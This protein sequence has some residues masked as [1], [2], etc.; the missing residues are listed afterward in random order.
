MGGLRAGLAPPGAGPGA[1]GAGRSASLTE[2]GAAWHD[3]P[4]GWVGESGE[5]G[6]GSQRGGM[7]QPGPKAP[8][9]PAA[10]ARARTLLDVFFARVDATPD[11][12]AL[13][14]MEVDGRTVTTTWRQWEQRSRA[15]A[16]GL[17]DLGLAPGAR[18]ALLSQTRLEW[19]LLD[20]AILMAG[21]ISVP[22]YANEQPATCARLLEDSGARVAIAENPWQ[23]KKLLDMDPAISETLGLILIE[24]ELRLQTGASA[25]TAELGVRAKRVETLDQLE[26]RG[27]RRLAT[28]DAELD[29]RIES[30][31]PDACVTICY[32]PGTEGREKGVMLTHEGFVATCGAL[33]GVL[34]LGA[35]DLQLL[36]LPLAQAFGR[37]GLWFGVRAGVPTALA[38][39]WRTVFE[40]ARSWQ[41]TCLWGA[42]RL[43]EKAQEG[44]ESELLG[45]GGL[46]SL[47]AGWA[48]GRP[49]DRPVEGLLARGRHALGERLVKRKVHARFGGRLRFA[50]SGGA[51][52]GAETARFFA[53]RDLPILESYG[54]VETTAATHIARLGEHAPGTVGRALPG[55]EFKLLEDGE[56]L[57]RG[58]NVTPG[59]WGSPAETRKVFDPEGWFH[60]GDL[61]RLD[62]DGRLVITDRKRDI[63]VTANG[64]AIAP[65]P[66]AERLRADPV[67]GQ[68]YI[69]GDRR[70]FLTAL[71]HLDAEGLARLAADLDL[72]GDYEHLTRHPRVFAYVDAVVDRVNATLSPHETIRKF[73]LMASEPTTE[74]GVLTPMLGLRRRVYADKHKALLDSF[75]SEP[76]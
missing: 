53:T 17:L 28:G 64:K 74:S 51:P 55:V 76:F 60:T 12:V 27:R 41:P 57:V 39:S 52:L 72:E 35:D 44:I 11:V 71:I 58:P 7:H 61:A 30:I 24:S 23:L 70:T 1:A 50:V 75:Y 63:I 69:H 15:L 45:S 16:S 25:T 32:T 18:V 34:P 6:E 31:E 26:A 22:I 46:M 13:R 59:Y 9:A 14:T 5:M 42:P 3:R 2:V 21:G 20:A 36:Y 68:V 48:L 4:A 67:I 47:V 37:L 8:P 33:A 38:R 40:D 54:M 43:F 49:P 73:A 56:L 62:G 29:E 19:A 65:G 66:I 10:I